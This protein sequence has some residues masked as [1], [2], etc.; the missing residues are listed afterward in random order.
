M[1]LKAMTQ[2]DMDRLTD[3]QLLILMW[4]TQKLADETWEQSFHYQIEAVRMQSALALRG[5]A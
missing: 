5:E 4:Q 1:K 2:A 3:E